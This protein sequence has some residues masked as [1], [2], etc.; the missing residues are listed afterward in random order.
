MV[1]VV[2]Y[3]D[4]QCNAVL[5]GYVKPSNLCA[6]TSGGGRGHCSVRRRLTYREF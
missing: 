5:E 4:E 1:D 2:T 6:G 3:T